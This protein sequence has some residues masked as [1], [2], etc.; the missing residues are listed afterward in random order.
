[1]CGIAVSK[2]GIK[3]YV[4]LYF[5]EINGKDGDD[6]KGIEPIG[7]RLYRYEFVDDKLV[8]PKLLLDLPAYPGPRHNGGAIEIGPDN[9]IYIPVGDID[10]SF[11][12]DFQHTQ[13]QNFAG[14]KVVADGRSGILRITQD[15]EP[16]DEGILGDS[17]PLGLYY[18][19]GIRNSFGLDFDPVTGFLWETENGPQDGDEI[20]LVEPGFNSG[21]N[22]IYG[23]SSSRTGFDLNE[24]V[25][26]DDRGH[27]EEPKLVWTRS[28][29][30]TGIIFLDSDRLGGQ[31]RNDMF[32]GSVNNGHILHFELNSQRNDIAVPQ[33]LAK[34]LIQN[35]IN[36]GAQNVI[37]TSGLGGITDLTVGPD[38]YLYIVSISQGKIFR[39]L[40]YLSGTND[41]ESNSGETLSALQ[42]E[43]QQNIP[44]GNLS[45]TNDIG[46]ENN[47]LLV[48]IKAL[49]N[50]VARGDFQNVT[51]IVTDSASRPISNA[52]ISG[53]LIYPGGNFEKKFKG[54]TDLHGKFVY[55]WLI[56]ENGDFGSLSVDVDVSSQGYP[57]SSVTGS[58]DIVESSEE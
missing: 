49:K 52:E 27:Y 6:R 55:S 34:R 57:P 20:N 8:N 48:S 56:G 3:T 22:E 1:M 30:L 37:F 7:N 21:W 17:M 51:I 45:K 14:G 43:E 41:T 24:L 16:V 54:I 31:Y 36:V 11:K 18:A 4:F 15:G 44:T 28:T 40:P 38:G 25:T 46:Y 13:T 47:D 26:F 23:F 39:I 10:G 50:S 2:N 12:V 5:T 58:F 19:Y 9:N 53:N 42:S 33:A 32:V 29:G 35:P